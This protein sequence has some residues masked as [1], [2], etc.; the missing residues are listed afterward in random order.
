V[1][2]HAG[3]SKDEIAASLGLARNTVWQS[4]ETVETSGL[5]IP[6]GER[7]LAGA[8]RAAGGR[9]RLP[10]LPA[11]GAAVVS[12][13]KVGPQGRRASDAQQP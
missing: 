10:V 9:R 12:G 3:R 1:H 2:W 13:V 6:R 7:A 4:P 11:C 8:L 5:V